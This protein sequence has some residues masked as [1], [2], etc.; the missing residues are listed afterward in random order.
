[1]S[2]TYILWFHNFFVLLSD[3]A[4]SESNEYSSATNGGG[5]EEKNWFQLHIESIKRYFPEYNVIIK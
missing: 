5:G 2:I 1:M 4:S 3:V